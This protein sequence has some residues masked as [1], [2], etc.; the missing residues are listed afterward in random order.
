MIQFAAGIM[1]P[2]Q[3]NF[4]HPGPDKPAPHAS[5]AATLG[6][7]A[8]QMRAKD[9]E[10]LNWRELADDGSMTTTAHLVHVTMTMSTEVKRKLP[11]EGVRWLYLRSEA[12]SIINGR[13]DL[14]VLIF[15]EG[16][17]LIAICNQVAQIVPAL[18][19]NQRKAS[20]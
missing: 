4:I 1:M 17:E 3:E 6:F 16:M 8:A 14:E 13:M 15:D 12:K 10:R 2:V 5:V 20:L 11:E 19:K 18:E 9:E 7:G